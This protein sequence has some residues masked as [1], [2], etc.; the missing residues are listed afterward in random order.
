[1]NTVA[2]FLRFTMLMFHIAMQFASCRGTL[3]ACW[4]NSCLR[5]SWFEPFEPSSISQE[6]SSPSGSPSCSVLPGW[7]Y[8][9]IPG[10]TWFYW[11]KRIKQ[12]KLGYGNCTL[13]ECV[14]MH[15][16]ALKCISIVW[17]LVIFLSNCKHQRSV[18]SDVLGVLLKPARVGCL[19]LGFRH[20]VMRFLK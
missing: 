13:E 15:Q 12:I 9:V 6:F 2:F 1:M 17:V 18:C 8:P 19:A 11:I 20:L 16:N 7:S 3:A 10:H 4:A 14:R 5:S